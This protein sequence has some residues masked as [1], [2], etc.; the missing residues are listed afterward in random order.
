MPWQRCQMHRVPADLQGRQRNK[1]SRVSSLQRLFL[2]RLRI[3]RILP[4]IGMVRFGASVNLIAAPTN[5]ARIP[6]RNR[7]ERQGQS[8]WTNHN[9]RLRAIPRS[10]IGGL[11]DP[12]GTLCGVP[13]CESPSLI[14]SRYID[15]REC[16]VSFRLIRDRRL[17]ETSEANAILDA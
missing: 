2:H 10:I 4:A 5:V 8:S 7:F 15:C 13:D 16:V 14:S 12:L 17:H 11:S 9:G 6:T 3:V 1:R